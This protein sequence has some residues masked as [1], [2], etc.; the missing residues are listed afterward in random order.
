MSCQLRLDHYQIEYVAVAQNDGYDA[1]LSSH[2]GDISSSINISPHKKDP[3]R[4]RLRLEV[5]VKPTAKKEK[6]FFPYQ[7]AIKGR[8]FFDIKDASS[9]E[10]TNK[11]LRLNGAAILYGLLRAQVAQI[12]AQS[13][14]GQ[15]LLP[16]MNF[17]EAAKA[18][19]KAKANKTLKKGK[20]SPKTV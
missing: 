4:Y 3:S 8:A 2:T 13:V 20:D 10:E 18:E 5:Q 14:H 7:V 9:P 12:T 19:P 15:F 17:V 6:E 16:T 1:A 11:F